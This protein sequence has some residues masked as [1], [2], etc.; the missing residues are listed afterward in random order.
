[1]A[2]GSTNI[3]T[4]ISMKK[5]NRSIIT[6]SVLCTVFPIIPFPLSKNCI[7]DLEFFLC[8]WKKNFGDKN[9]NIWCFYF[10]V[11]GAFE[12]TVADK[13][14]CKLLQHWYLEVPGGLITWGSLL[15]LPGGF[16]VCVGV[17][18]GSW[19][20]RVRWVATIS[21]GRWFVAVSEGRRM[22]TEN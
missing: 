12:Q 7:K 15:S 6:S 22:A 14:E 19:V 3:L 10:N 4:R 5:R 11:S 9:L 8:L 21:W 2:L 1:M 18:E 13:P 17:W 20:N 16:V